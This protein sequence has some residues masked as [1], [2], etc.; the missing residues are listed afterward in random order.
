MEMTHFRMHSLSI[1]CVDFSP[2]FGGKQ[3]G[4]GRQEEEEKREDNTLLIR[5]TH[6]GERQLVKLRHNRARARRL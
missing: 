5:R 3:S 1:E 2:S 6:A 4:L